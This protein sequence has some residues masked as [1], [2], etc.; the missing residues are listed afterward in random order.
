MV[1]RDGV[2]CISAEKDFTMVRCEPSKLKFHGLPVFQGHRYMDSITAKAFL[3]PDSLLDSSSER[4]KRAGNFLWEEDRVAFWEVLDQS[5]RLL[6]IPDNM[7]DVIFR[8]GVGA[9]YKSV[10]ALR[11]MH[12]NGVAHRDLK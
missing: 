7:V 4:P 11:F 8:A 10:D 1:E 6:L 2:V 9:V 12:N 5:S 3:E